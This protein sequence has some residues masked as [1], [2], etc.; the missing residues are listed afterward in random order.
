MLELHVWGPAFSLPSIDPQC[1]ATIAYLVKAVP[2]EEWVLVA[3]SDPSVSPTNELP[4]LRNGDVWVSKFRNIVDYVRQYSDQ[5]WDLDA[6][7]TGL[8]NADITAFSA[9]VESNGQLL[10]DLSLY[11][12]SQNYYASTSPAYGSILTWPN[13][14][15]LPPKL[16]HAAKHRT[17][18]LGLSSLDLEASEEQR[19]RERSA[20]VSAGQIPQSLI[21]RPRETVSS[22]LGKTARSSHFRLDALTAELFEPLEQLLGKKAY[23]LADG[24]RPSSLDALV[25]GYLSLAL[26]P[27][28]PAAWLRESLR[29]KTPRLASYVERLREECF[30]AAVQL[31]DAF[32]GN[33]TK[34]PLPLPWQKPERINAAKIGNTLLNTL[35]DATP[36]L[37]EFRMNSRLQQ[38]AKSIDPRSS[39]YSESEARAIS[40]YAIAQRRDLYISI[41]SVA[42]GVAAM[43][44][45]LFYNGVITIAGE[46]EEYDEDED[47]DVNIGGSSS[48]E[49]IL[50]IPIS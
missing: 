28:V 22:L 6:E 37:K 11:V 43:V 7:W 40:E 31:E 9:F 39:E 50:G 10:I 42:A 45:Y 46:E 3:S 38:A 36:I 47:V 24:R 41:A 48:A 44:G 4:A 34:K 13:Q 35:A 15:I 32:S 19:E 12:S 25:L 8:D 30:G 1:L 23:F 16:R 26:V 49:D 2:K 17:E 21:S 29:T 14:W 33:T 5:A 20:A 18:H 27:E